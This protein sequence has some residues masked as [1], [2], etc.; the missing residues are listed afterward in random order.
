[1]RTGLSFRSSKGTPTRVAE[2]SAQPLALKSLVAAMSA[3]LG[4]GHAAG[5]MAASNIN[6]D[7]RTATTV[8]ASAAAGHN[9]F[10]V[11]T[12]TLNASGNTG[13]NSF[14]DF[15][16]DS[17]DTVNMHVPTGAKNLVNLVWDSQTVIN[18]TLNSY[19]GNSSKIGGNVFFADP[20]GIV[21]GN[22]ATLNVGA[23]SLSAPTSD[24]MASLLDSSGNVDPDAT[25]VNLLLTGQEP[26]AAS[27]SGCMI[28]ID[29][30]INAN[31]AVRVRATAIDVSG[32][33]YVQGDATDTLSTAVNVAGQ[34]DPVIVSDGNTIRLVVDASEEAGF[35]DADAKATVNVSGTLTTDSST[36][37]P[38]AGHAAAGTWGLVQATAHAEATAE[39]KTPESKADTVNLATGQVGD[40]FKDQDSL[41]ENGFASAAQD[42]NLA[43]S[44]KLGQVAYVRASAVATVN[45]TG[46]ILAAGDV[47]LS[48]STAAKAATEATSE[49]GA[50]AAPVMVGAMYGA[51]Y[52][53]ATTHVDSGASVHAGGALAVNSDTDNELDV[54]ADTVA[55]DQALATTVAWSQAAVQSDSTLAGDIKAQSIQVLAHNSNSFATEAKAETSPSTGSV[56]VAGAVSLQTVS[57]NAALNSSPTVIAGGNGDVVVAAGSDTSKNA[58]SASTGTSAES[59]A[60]TQDKTADTN[61]DLGGT[62]AN[63]SNGGLN[64]DGSSGSVALPFHLGA[65]VAYTD[66]KNTSHASIGDGVTI[67]TEGSVTVYSNLTDA[68]IH[69]GATSA[70]VSKADE[71]DT[72]GSGQPIA[73]DVAAAVAYANYSHD[74]SATIGKN[75]DITAENIG[76]GSNVNIPFDWYF[77]NA[78][79]VDAIKNMF[80]SLDQF[81]DGAK[82]LKDLAGS[83]PEDITNGVSG[84]ASASAGGDTP[85]AVGGSVNY[86]AMTNRN[87]AWVGDGATLHA[88][89]AAAATPGQDS[90][91]SDVEWLSSP[92]EWEH[93]IDVQADTTVTLFN[94]VGDITPWKQ[95]TKGDKAAIGGAFN[96]TGYK[97]TTIAG[98]GGDASLT[99]DHNDVAV[100]ATSTDRMIALSPIS[101]KGGTLAFQGT[102]AITDVDDTTHATIS[103]GS[104]VDA[105]A[106]DVVASN[107]VMI[108]SLSGALAMSS[109]ASIGIS[110]G[111]NQTTTDTVAKIGDNRAD[112][113]AVTGGATAPSESGGTFAVDALNVNAVSSGQS[114]ALSLAGSKGGS[115]GSSSSGSGSSGDTGEGESSG[116]QGTGEGLTSL[117]E[118]IKTVNENFQAGVAAVDGISSLAGG[119]DDGSGDSMLDKAGEV[120]EQISSASEA[121]GSASESLNK[122]KDKAAGTGKSKGGADE[123]TSKSKGGKFGI[124]VSGS[125]S[126]NIAHLGAHAELQGVTVDNGSSGTDVTVQAL[127]QASL[128][129]GSGAAALSQS[130]SG[131]AGAIAGAVAYSSVGNTTTA[132]ITGSTLNNIDHAVVRALDGS[133]QVDVA[134]GVAAN[135]SNGTSTTIAGSVS[136]GK[137]ANTTHAGIE[138]GSTLTAGSAADSSVEVT[139]YDHSRIGV[140]G[141]SLYFNKSGATS[142]NV[143][144]GFTYAD[145]G[146]TTSADLSGHTGAATDNDIAGFKSL[147]LRALD[148][149]LIGAGS[150]AGGYSAS[151]NSAS[152]AG[153]IV[154]TQIGNTTQASVDSGMRLGLDGDVLIQASAVAPISELDSIVGDRDTEGYDFSGSTLDA[155]SVDHSGDQTA[156]SDGDPSQPGSDALTLGDSG[157]GSSIIAIA[158][159]VQIGGNNV[160]LSYVGNNVHNTHTVRI[161]DAS[162]DTTGSVQLG[163]HDDTRIV[164]L[165]VGVGVSSGQFAGLGSATSNIVGNTDSILLGSAATAG[166][167]A[168]IHADSLLAEASDDTKIYS[169]A[170]NV[171]IGKGQAAAG[172]AVTYNDIANTI[173]THAGNT[174]LDIGNDATM[175][176]D[177]SALIMAGAVAGAASKGFALTLS[178]GWN[179]TADSNQVLIDDASAISAGSLSLGAD[180]SATIYALSGGVS[181]GGRAAVGLAASVSDIGD[182]T[183]AGIS[184]AGLNVSAGAVNVKASGTG[185]QYALSVAGAVGTQ[186]AGVAGAETTSLISSDVTASVANVYGLKSDGSV[187]TAAAAQA[188]SLSVDAENTAGIYSLAGGIGIG[189]SVGVGAAATIADVG[190][191]TS[192]S[193]SDATLDVTDTT[194]VKAHAGTTIDTASLAGSAAS[195]VAVS[196]SDT[197]NLI[198]N[199]ISAT[200]TNVAAGDASD[201]SVVSTNVTTVSADNDATINALSGAVGGAG[202]VAVGAAVSVNNIAT[203]TRASFLGSADGSSAGP[204][205][206]AQQ[207]VVQAGTGS[208]SHVNTIAV[209]AAG[210]GSTAVGGSVAVNLLGGTT[211]ATIA[212]Q[213]DV[214]AS[215]NVGVLAVN[216]QGINVFAGQAAIGGDA[217][218]G[219]GVVVNK[220]DGSTDASIDNSAVSAYGNGSALSV[221]AGAA[222]K[223]DALQAG[224]DIAKSDANAKSISDPTNYLAPDLSGSTKSVHGVAVNAANQQSIAT[225][226]IGAS[227]SGGAAVSAQVGVNIVGGSTSASI[228]D[229]NINQA[230]RTVQSGSGTDIGDNGVYY[231]H[232]ASAQQ[233][234]VTAGSRQY[235]ANFIVNVAGSGGGSATGSV[236]TNV[237]NVD[238]SATLSGSTVSAQGAAAVDAVGQQWSLLT[239][240]GASVSGGVGGAASG[241]VNLFQASTTATLDG[242]SLDAGSLDV[243]A[244]GDTVSAQFTGALGIGIGAA[245]LAG[246]A[247]VNVDS[248]T[249]TAKIDG[250]ATVTAG[251]GVNVKANSKNVAQSIVVGAA[252][253]SSVGIAG[254]AVVNV[255]SNNTHASIE[256]GSSVTAA[257]VAVDALDQQFISAYSGVLGGGF[258]GAGGGMNLVL[259][260][261]SVGAAV[262]N[263]TVHAFGPVYGDHGNVDVHA[264]SDR[265]IQSVA[266]AIGG[267][268][269]G[270]GLSASVVV[271]GT[272]DITGGGGAG[273]DLTADGQ[274]NLNNLDSLSSGSKLDS[275]PSSYGLSDSQLSSSDLAGINSSASYNLGGATGS[276][277]SAFGGN[278]GV[279]AKISG[280]SV[281]ANNGIDVG[282]SVESNTDNIAGSGAVGVVGVGGSVAYTSLNSDI[283][284]SVDGGTATAG[285]GI[286]IH[287]DAGDYN[288]GKAA[289]S[290]AYAG[291]GGL[292]GVGAAVAISDVNN[293]VST[294]AGGTLNSSRSGKGTLSLKASDTSTSLA[295]NANQKDPNGINVGGVVAG[296]VVV[297]AIRSSTVSATLADSAD[298]NNFAALTLSASD[299]GAITANGVMGSGG[300]LTAISAVVAT[301]SDSSHVTAHI[302]TQ[303]DIAVGS[304][305][306]SASADPVMNAGAVGITVGGIGGG[307]GANVAV[308]DMT[309]SVEASVAD[310]AVFHQGT[311]SVDASV[312]PTVNASSSGGAGAAMLGVNASTA[313]AT[314]TA[315]ANATV[316][317][318][319]TLPTTSVSISATSD[320]HQ[321]ASAT[322]VSV[323]LVAAGASVAKATSNTTLNATLGNGLLDSSNNPVAAA[324]TGALSVVAA[325]SDANIAYSKAGSGGLVSGNGASATTS[326]TSTSSASVG[327]HL[328]LA[329]L[330]GFQLSATQNVE[331]GG[332]ANSVLAAAVGGSGADVS[333]TI[334]TTTNA[335]IGDGTV[336]ATGGNIDVLA[337]TT[338]ASADGHNVGAT[339]GAGGVVTGTA[340]SVNTQVT[341]H[342]NL[343]VGSDVQLTSGLD[344]S[345]SVIG[346]ISMVAGTL[347]G[348]MA[349]ASTISTGGAVPIANAK[350]NVGGQFD[351]DLEV[352]DGS[353]L[354]SYGRTN[355][356]TYTVLDQVAATATSNSWGAAPV[357]ASSATINLQSDQSLKVGSN[358]HIK[359]YDEADIV[360]GRDILGLHKTKLAPSAV[361]QSYVR[362]FIAIPHASATA[363]TVSNATLTMGSGSTVTG[364]GDV[365][366]GA[367]QGD[368][369]V[370]TDGT[371]HGYELGFIPATQHSNH[372]SS[373]GTTQTGIDGTVVAGA[374]NKVKLS[375][376]ADGTVDSTGTNAPF[377]VMVD[378][379]LN[380]TQELNTLNGTPDG[381]YNGIDNANVGGILFDPIFVGGGNVYLY[382]ASIGGSGT[383]TAQ[384]AP[385]V[386]IDNASPYYMFIP[387]IE[388]T[389]GSSGSVLVSGG[390]NPS[391]LGG[392]TLHQEP[393][394]V[395]PTVTI[396]STYP[397]TPGGPTPGIILGDV[398]NLGGPLHIKDLA[399]SLLERGQIQTNSQ[400]VYV[401]NG[402]VVVKPTSGDVWFSGADPTSNLNSS[403]IK[404]FLDAA[405]SSPDNAAAAIAESYYSLNGVYFTSHA[406]NEQ[407]KVL[408]L[409]GSC[410]PHTGGSGSEES[411]DGC[412]VS[413]PIGTTSVL[414]RPVPMIPS[415]ALQQSGKFTGNQLGSTGAYTGQKFI[416]E[417]KYI[418]IDGAIN[419]GTPATWTVQTTA[420]LKDFIAQKKAEYAQGLITDP[421]IRLTTDSSGQPLLTLVGG[422]PSQLIGATYNVVNNQLILDNVNA[423]GGGSVSLS[424]KIVSTAQ[425]SINVNSGY[426][427]VTVDNTTGVPLVVQNVF[428]GSGGLGLITVDDKLKTWTSG[429]NAGKNV[430]TWYVSQNGE[431]AKI[432]DNYNGATDWTDAS[433]RLVGNVSDTTQYAPKAGVEYQW[434]ASTSIARSY[435]RTSGNHSWSLGDW[436]WASASGGTA[437]QHWA[438]GTSRFIDGNGSSGYV[439]LAGNDYQLSISGSFQQA[440]YWDVAYHG[441]DSDGNCHYG[442]HQSGTDG[443]GNAAS[444]WGF[445]YPYQGTLTVTDTQRADLPININFVTSASNNVDITSDN[446]ILLSGQI[447]NTNGPTSVHATQGDIVQSN[448]KA[449]IWTHSLALAAD[450]GEIGSVNDPL[451]VKIAHDS[452]PGSTLTASTGGGDIS[453]NVDSGSSAQA[454]SALASGA[455]GYGDVLIRSTGSL[456][457]IAGHS[458]DV[459][460][461]DVN[462]TSTQGGIGSIAT[463]LNI[464]T[465]ADTLA[466]GAPSGGQ[467]DAHGVGDVAISDTGGDVWVGS[468][469]S[470]NGDVLLAAPNGGIYDARQLDADSTLSS[471]Q[472]KK[473]WDQLHLT[474]GAAADTTIAAIEQQVDA[475]YA[476]YY[477]LL[478][479]GTVSNG[480]YT[481]NSDAVD[482]YW[483]LAAAANGMDASSAVDPATK[484]SLTQ[485]YVSD[486]YQTIVSEFGTYIG[487]DWKSQS[488]FAGSDP[489]AS[490]NFTLDPT[491]D[492]YKN[493]TQDSTWTEEQLTSAIN[494]AALGSPT[495][496]TVG[497]VAPNISGKNIT[498]TAGDGGIG[499]TDTPLSITY[500]ALK[501]L[502]A[503][504]ATALTAQQI[505][506][507]GLANAPGDVQLIDASG[508]VISPNDPDLQ[509]KLDHLSVTQTMPLYVTATGTVTGSA[510]AS[511]YLQANGDLHFDSFSSGTDMRVAATGS[512]GA[513]D[514]V[515]ASKPVLTTGGDL[516][517]TAGGGYIGLGNDSS[518]GAGDALPVQIGGELRNASAATDLLLSQLSGDLRVGTVFANG[519]VSLDA[520]TGS[521]LAQQDSLSIQGR[522][523]VLTA[524]GDIGRRSSVSTGVDAPLKLQVGSDGSLD[525]TAGGAVNIDS[526]TGNLHVGTITSGGNLVLTSEL[527]NLDAKH[528]TS[529]GGTITSTAGGDGSY[530]DV[531]ADGDVTLSATGSFTE[532][533][534][535]STQG[536]ITLTGVTGMQLKDIDAQAGVIVA[537][538]IGS[539]SPAMNVVDGGLLQSASDITLQSS[540]SLAMG[541]GSEVSSGGLAKLTSTGSMTLGLVAS[542]ATSGTGVQ[543]D[544]GDAI[545]GN[546]D[547]VNLRSRSGATVDLHAVHDIGSAALPIVVDVDT[548]QGSS[549]QGSIWLHGL[550]D[551]RFTDL[552]AGQGNL[553]LSAQGTLAYDNLVSGGDSILQANAI[554]GT[555]LQAGGSASF[556][557]TADTTVD[558]VHT[559][560]FLNMQAGGNLTATTLYVGTDAT[561]TAGGVLSYTGLT[562]GG[563]SVLQGDR[564]LGGTLVAGGRAQLTSTHDT[565]VDSIQTGQDLAM[566][567]GG[568]LTATTLDVGTDATL[569][570]GGVLSYTSLTS[571]GDSVLQGDNILGGTLVAD[572]RAQLTSTH[573][574]T[575]DAIQTGQDLTMNAG[576]ELTATTL[577]SGTE[578][579][580]SAGGDLNVTALDA[581]TFASI[582]S[583]GDTHAGTVRTGTY[584]SMEAGRGLYADTLDVGTDATL[585][586][587]SAVGLGAVTTGN[588]LSADSGGNL[589]ADTLDIGGDA[590]LNAT[591]TLSL[592]GA[593]KT[594]GDL[595]MTSGQHMSFA[596]LDAGGHV[597]GQSLHGDIDGSGVTATDW[598]KFVAAGS[599]RIGSMQ[600]GTDVTLQAG[601]NVQADRIL[602]G[603]DLDVTAGGN[604]DLGSATAANAIIMDAGGNLTAHDLKAGHSIDLAANTMSFASLEAPDSITLLAR[605]GDITADTLTTRD[606]FVSAFGA[607][608]LDAANIGD[609]INLAGNTIDAH[610]RQTSTGQPL[611][612]ALTGFQDG[613]AQ[614]ITIDAE[615]PQQWMIDRLAAVNA[616]LATT[617]PSVH[618]EQGHI[619][620][621]L[622]LDTADARIRM[623]QHDPALV[624]A[625]VQLMQKTYDF[626]LY[627]DDVHTLTDAFVVRYGDGYQIQTPNYVSDH[628]WVAPDYYGDAAL[629]YNGRALT[630][631]T[632]ERGEDRIDGFKPTWTNSDGSDLVQPD[633]S[634]EGAP[635]NTKAPR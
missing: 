200:M 81:V 332:E 336:V 230:D 292:V 123:E 227:V 270:T 345:E 108:W 400:D 172:G 86:F 606:A 609:R 103:A 558:T 361:S 446:S 191:S 485:Q 152:L 214:I 372:Q 226:G 41:A 59:T 608:R 205:Y 224:L 470:E 212:H 50:N 462:L 555:T 142:G 417:A 209:G 21:V 105:R 143:G 573:D 424:G 307:I 539:G 442:T 238:T 73:V 221:D 190:G 420:A 576:G 101:G 79:N 451:Q 219:I 312:S 18:G 408:V 35:G 585:H 213:A 4:V 6:K 239:A 76:V 278:D 487:A 71:G 184:D 264:E 295:G 208:A 513:A 245:G 537:K 296:A 433:A 425:G 274:L 83:T 481:L 163:A 514:G 445:I 605:K 11:T 204:V 629:R 583:G 169:L 267:G 616:A 95:S 501:D 202:S 203:T 426:G 522:D 49:A 482:L 240:V 261:S 377:N 368:A 302:G 427:S 331:Y 333:N 13:F 273:D 411:L 311:L 286:A 379:T 42:A 415:I 464:E 259:L 577:K 623:N 97:N 175:N 80:G 51:I 594:G 389:F 180:N 2:K 570:A 84:Y 168:S 320:T 565:T 216:Q 476:Q 304:T 90:W 298:V 404:A 508:N 146:N 632:D 392:L 96:Y 127:D 402:Y 154:W 353:H 596:T 477:Q 561:L 40:L 249:T 498:L 25:A 459:I 507:L 619:E 419:A 313:T 10:D 9:T 158:G 349:D 444:I 550:G 538:L 461:R 85:V 186:G 416:V 67:D 246:A 179:Q 147:T 496:G 69:N 254:G 546:G 225:L 334:N 45:I 55:G 253:G 467:L 436:D 326:A 88:T 367:V 319:V 136:I 529:T 547:A 93:S 235:E 588:D 330:S 452:T 8:A 12:T 74:A 38:S 429:V 280:G 387:K 414:N 232:A 391:S 62:L 463:P 234:D 520:P 140:G 369:T 357:G 195:S 151:Q 222:S 491:S 290:T 98:V 610:I 145:I 376:A 63:K 617:A 598:I 540:G 161:D 453:L 486:R 188:L 252:G 505:T 72:D 185:T 110:I 627:Q 536:D 620:N 473:I 255:V 551:V 396:N 544:A 43:A 373:T 44:D 119:S 3:V 602:A 303:A 149:S 527:G 533:S 266:V 305:S 57:A 428:A 382:G 518:G 170:G 65:A 523:I 300:I 47:A 335:T 60:E 159:T 121:V 575:V 196:A 291:V 157:V 579:A 162:I 364:G 634:V 260:Q 5:A 237:F 495:G 578:A 242:G 541:A 297:D 75:A 64:A 572:G 628:L 37:A 405:I 592:T 109:E 206:K 87:T 571:G 211:A 201:S 510:S 285:Y 406:S 397:S 611:Y 22:G 512:I 294:T 288:G 401:P 26:E 113:P 182:S 173:T 431:P 111:I 347:V 633:P 189:Q 399:G 380:P 277:N 394:D 603:H 517:L 590:A 366:I 262:Q 484:A 15:Q 328:D 494:E 613:V 223:A 504:S 441:C 455:Q 287:A 183:Q 346:H 449:L 554:D 329:S 607:I 70:A 340:A 220:I 256:G 327:Q 365:A 468:V 321:N 271:A 126:V 215:D 177:E 20:H 138:G 193:L 434:T 337:K 567:A 89:S 32:T 524:D 118:N 61:A 350:V 384:G 450:A 556:T 210:G 630:L 479:V 458:V 192:A 448:D 323:G 535:R 601:A 375:I 465:H 324:T 480:Q 622:S 383:I 344:A 552:Q 503:G 129:S 393:S 631:H 418:D 580:L 490:F 545:A 625:D 591:G 92:L 279:Q 114:G 91:E 371:G 39:Y 563:N 299:S 31:S 488:A 342:N 115:N 132:L 612:S 358:V 325:G 509:N 354:L 148:S 58:T 244:Q 432:Y 133:L 308:A 309:A 293:T 356:A 167:T 618:I 197:T 135:T 560:S 125:A 194:D 14:H 359:S 34:T 569:T 94:L 422:Q 542:T 438:L 16:L 322:G 472:A 236:A 131:F 104:S 413:G 548:L 543:L 301:A 318:S 24:F 241:G 66:S 553:D 100:N 150:V 339:G 423:S 500:Q 409:Y 46:S 497:T 599:I 624:P 564:I 532:G 139:A 562:S 362:G 600:A 378:K 437:G 19:V 519:L 506:A 343:K 155:P 23:L 106:V 412:N 263:S 421:N 316:G 386:T 134:L 614:R 574:T 526:P 447:T 187:D 144:I 30:T 120:M 403:W 374:F 521:I 77:G 231:T 457:G 381:T 471:D 53:K 502:Y 314:D 351:N 559:G 395:L 348:G 33:I 78:D 499:R 122:L 68:G 589:D 153:A 460:G 258:V 247:G 284:A 440:A 566:Q 124:G 489:V 276:G 265:D 531:Q 207:L 454:F 199:S 515:D 315:S 17:G 635:V 272:G 582:V 443:S 251:N 493:L 586:G 268:A 385:S 306:V 128:I 466:N 164:G 474:D 27:G 160:G 165:A 584:L 107:P 250:G 283:Q 317:N 178:F 615:V 587:A 257:D 568:N 388:T 102:V 516:L 528:L 36:T 360:A 604:I 269:V 29:G 54:S 281:T 116:G 176:A 198:H 228:T 7:G 137:S 248:T 557:S 233:V 435:D 282:A 355:I 398:I 1:M 456:V 112:D 217:G 370:S 130:K 597:F 28:C 475:G 156:G 530:D 478:K 407:A 439:D 171:A 390:A 229:A 352:G 621:S 341:T 525:A 430:V 469:T 363:N 626:K 410:A 511:V 82:A 243:L 181:I 48:S 174:T 99:S 338:L 289:K 56:G 218:V 310:Y 534:V 483:P 275:D 581:G 595:D 166:H 593:V 52:S 549:D 492:A 117:I 141:G